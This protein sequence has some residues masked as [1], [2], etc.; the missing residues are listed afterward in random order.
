MDVPSLYFRE[1]PIEFPRRRPLSR[2]PGADLY[3]L[4]DQER[5]PRQQFS[6]GGDEVIAPVQVAA[7]ILLTHACEIDNSTKA[8]ALVALIRPMRVVPQASCE[9]IRTGKNLRTLWLPE[10]D[11]PRFEESYVDFSRITSLRLDALPLDKRTFVCLGATSAHSLRA[12]NAVPYP[13]RR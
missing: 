2:G 11:A 6:P 5:V 10:N 4:G 13:V 1:G 7:S 12:A 8:C 9:P 3:T